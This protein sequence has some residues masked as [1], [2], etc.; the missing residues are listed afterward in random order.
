MKRVKRRAKGKQRTR[1]T[2]E[3]DREFV[4]DT[5]AQASPAERA[6]FERARRKPGRPKSGQGAHVISVSVERAL[7]AR[8]DEL[9]KELGITRARLIA[10][11]LKAV[12]AAEGRI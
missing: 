2:A 9:A 8:T 6:R 7:L 3:F 12:L 10:R 5:F 11:G 4:A 1:G